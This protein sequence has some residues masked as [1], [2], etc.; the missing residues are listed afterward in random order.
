MQARRCF[1][2]STSK[3]RTGNRT[4]EADKEERENMSVDGRR[5][6]R[7]TCKLGG[8]SIATCHEDGVDERV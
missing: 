8:E 5:M 7:V 4:E 3:S 1:H 2:V 6:G